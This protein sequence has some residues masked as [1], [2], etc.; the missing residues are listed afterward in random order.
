MR[1]R[2]LAGDFT[3]LPRIE[4]VDA[5]VLSDQSGT[6]GAGTG[7]GAYDAAN[8]RILL[9]REL[10][11]G[12]AGRALDVLTE[13]IGHGLDARLNSLDTAGDEGAVFARLSSGDTLGA[14]ELASLRA[15]DDS[16][17]I[18]VNG[19]DVEVEFWI[20]NDLVN[21]ARDVVSDISDAVTDG[22]E[23]V[24]DTLSDG[25]QWVGDA[26]GDGVDAV[27]E[28]TMQPLLENTGS[29]GAFLDDHVVRPAVGLVND[30]IDIVT[31]T[32]DSI[33]DTSTHFLSNNVH[34]FGS[35][36]Q[37]DLSGA[38]SSV[39]QT[40]TD[41]FSDTMG[42][43]VENFVMGLH[44]VTSLT[45]GVLG[46]SETRALSEVEITYLKTIYGDSLDYSEI[47]IQRGGIESWGLIDMDPHTVGND[48]YLPEGN[49]VAEGT[50]DSNGVPIPEGTLT[51][52]GLELLSHETAH[53]W[54]FQNAGA[55]YLSTAIG[56]YV[57]DKGAAYD[58]ESALTDLTPWE[59]L[60]PDQQAE[61][62][63][64]IGMAQVVDGAGP[65]TQRGID[66][67]IENERGNGTFP[68]LSTDQL[69]Y[70]N[71]IQQRLLAGDA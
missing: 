12:D 49:F 26:I 25:V 43:M 18:N 31:N 1:Q 3:W 19:Q 23:S 5:S 64:L 15:E 63:M 40:G 47:R 65:I 36:L 24:G 61:F 33:V 13:E 32:V 70:I 42:A 38:W 48:I 16:G 58:Y 6:Q 29:V 55:G 71:A 37:G 9:S 28:Y 7:M 2:A 20:G 44:A 46:L 54:Q 30:G 21:G 51:E 14:S 45:N 62:A 41:L 22:I 57:D 52:A 4:V 8:D 56:T 67:A 11:G 17:T 60:T 53:A 35:L 10:L 59:D 68:S 50:L 39:V 27:Y 69:T 34:T 66:K